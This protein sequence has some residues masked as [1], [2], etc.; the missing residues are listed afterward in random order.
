MFLLI[1]LFGNLHLVLPIGMSVLK[2]L[3]TVSLG[4]FLN[5]RIL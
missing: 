2:H 1:F 4:K 5:Y 3:F